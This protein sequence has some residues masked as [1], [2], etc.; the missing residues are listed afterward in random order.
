MRDEARL[1]RP[2]AAGKNLV[3]YLTPVQTVAVS[4]LINRRAQA[5][6]AIALALMAELLFGADGVNA[7]CGIIGG[8]PYHCGQRPQPSTLSILLYADWSCHDRLAF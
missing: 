5:A 4:L 6:F 7:R 8:G 2:S 1:S 3:R